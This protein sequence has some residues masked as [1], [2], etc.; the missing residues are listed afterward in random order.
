[1]TTAPGQVL[2]PGV[3]LEMMSSSKPLVVTSQHA[4]AQQQQQQIAATSGVSVSSGTP[5]L[6]PSQAVKVELVKP[7][8]GVPPQLQVRT[9]HEPKK[10]AFYL[11]YVIQIT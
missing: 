8:F 10:I 1:M 3:K 7:P 11:R 6:M 4:Q 9:H 5:V 2:P